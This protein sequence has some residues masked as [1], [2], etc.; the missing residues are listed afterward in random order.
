MYIEIS[1]EVTN[2]G[3]GEKNGLNRRESLYRQKCTIPCGGLKDRKMVYMLLT[4]PVEI[5]RSVKANNKWKKTAVRQPSVISQYNQHMG[6]V[7]LSDQRV[8]T[9]A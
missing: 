1:M 4:T 6:G 5:E 2:P 9:Y 3:S 8:T 7:D